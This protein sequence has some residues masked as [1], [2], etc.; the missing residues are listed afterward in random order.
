MFAAIKIA[1]ALTPHALM[2]FDEINSRPT[3]ELARRLVRRIQKD[4][5]TVFTKR[6]A[7][8][9]LHR[10]AAEVDDVLTVLNERH[11]VRPEHDIQ[12]YGR[13]SERWEVNPKL[14]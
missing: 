10:K 8:R 1:M 4:K 11:Y 12:N 6:D 2:L 5:V 14:L 7:E 9:W 3:D 13:P